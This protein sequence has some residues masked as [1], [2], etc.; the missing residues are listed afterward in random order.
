MCAFRPCIAGQSLDI[1]SQ[2]DYEY[3]KQGTSKFSPQGKLYLLGPNPL[4][5]VFNLN[6]IVKGLVI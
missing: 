1:L 6:T 2:Y 5:I 4:T 3:C